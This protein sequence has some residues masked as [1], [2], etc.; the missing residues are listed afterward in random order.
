M[1]LIRWIISLAILSVWS[2]LIGTAL[3]TALY[4]AP[5][6]APN[7]AAIVVLGG[8]ADSAGTGLADESAARLNAGLGL[9]KSGAA[10]ILVLTGGGSPSV[11]DVMMEE[12]LN[13]GVPADAILLENKSLS[14]LQNAMFTADFDRLDKSAPIIVVTHKY[15]LPRANASFR[16]AGFSDVKNHAADP[17]AGF[18]LSRGLLWESVKWPANVLRAAAASAAEAG[19]VPRDSYLKYLE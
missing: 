5:E 11:A 17:D 13:A 19:S 9:Y 10:Q 14:T 6:N 18:T 7:A 16:W 1:S 12:A 8:A 2:A 15:H 4:S 3:Y